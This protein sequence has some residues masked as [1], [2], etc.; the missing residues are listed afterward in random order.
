[1]RK[2][3]TDGGLS[4][5]AIAGS[6][7]VILGLNITDDMRAGL[8]GFAISR[9]DGTEGETY[10]MQGTKVFKSVEPHPT[11]GGRVSSFAH[12]FQSFQWSD[13]TAKPGYSYTYTV[14]A[15]YGDPGALRP[16]ATAKVSVTTEPIEGAKHTIRFNRG[17]AAT[18]EYARRFQN[19]RPSE[20]GPAAYQWLSRGLLEGIIAFIQRAE[21]GQFG[22]KG[23]FYEFQWDEV[24]KELG[25]ANERGADV[26][27]VFD[28]IDNDSGPHGANEDAIKRCKIKSIT[29][30]R[31]NGTLM[32]NK[33]LVLTE[34]ENPRAVLFGS[35]NLTE[36]GLFGHAN[37]THVVE[38]AEIAGKYLTYYEKLTTDP[39]TSRGNT[40]KKWTIE[41]TP[42][43]ATD[44]VDGMAPV[45]SPRANTEALD[46][47]ANSPAA[48]KKGSS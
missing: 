15:M 37:C 44:F 20:V 26:K 29:K 23:A 11:P 42:A 24:L 46:G 22:L 9:D 1:M 10:W 43:P 16:G 41:Q 18:Q 14:I 36:N 39:E 25:A 6:Y 7:V 3:T 48:P 8:R 4:V 13:Y 21:N 32:H 27:V 40:Y 17:S 28:D 38:D 45:Y 5:N 35:T 2:R 31:T 19:K 34:N 30:P 47:T 12:P 33:F